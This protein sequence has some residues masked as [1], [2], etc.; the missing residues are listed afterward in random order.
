M[1]N[2]ILVL[3]GYVLIFILSLVLYVYLTSKAL[4]EICVRWANP[5]KKKSDRGLRKY[6][7]PE[8]RGVV[9]EP[10]LRVRRYMKQY[11]LICYKGNKYL[12]C[13]LNKKVRFIKYDVMVYGPSSELLDVISVTERVTEEKYSK[14]IPL[15]KDTSY[16][17]VV[18]RMAD[19]MYR[20]NETAVKYSTP[21]IVILAVLVGIFTLGEIYLTRFIATT[22]VGMLT[23]GWAVYVNNFRFLLYSVIL[24]V[25]CAFVFLLSYVRRTVKVINN[26]RR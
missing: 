6:T 23:S 3:A 26:E 15:H 7:F 14:A 17:N 25:V 24:S 8:G 21:S 10:E 2:N 9:Y 1:I 12:K 18:L 5:K 11:A 16:V 19:G 13:Y 4:P 20:N 22:V